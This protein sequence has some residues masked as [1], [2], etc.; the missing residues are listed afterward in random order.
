MGNQTIDAVKIGQSAL[1]SV[2][3]VTNQKQRISLTN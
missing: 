3:T 1:L 2:R